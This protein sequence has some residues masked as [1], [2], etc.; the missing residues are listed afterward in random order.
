MTI[1][2]KI[3]SNNSNSSVSYDDTRDQLIFKLFESTKAKD[4]DKIVK[5]IDLLKSVVNMSDFLDSYSNHEMLN[6]WL[7]EANRALK[8]G[9]LKL[10]LES[11]KRA[12]SRELTQNLTDLIQI[13][14]FLDSKFKNSQAY[15]KQI[16]KLPKID[17][18]IYNKW[19]QKQVELATNMEQK[20][21]SGLLQK[22]FSDYKNN[23]FKSSKYKDL[24][25]AEIIGQP[26]TKASIKPYFDRQVSFHPNYAK[27]KLEDFVKTINDYEFPQVKPINKIIELFGKKDPTLGFEKLELLLIDYPETS[28]TL[29]RELLYTNDDVANFLNQTKIREFDIKAIKRKY[30]L[31]RAELEKKK[32]EEA[33]KKAKLPEDSESRKNREMIL[34][35]AIQRTTK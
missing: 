5:N 23:I 34:K 3:S 22:L 16:G 27:I 8:K 4:H 18:P 11:A 17:N 24:A 9:N 29:Q 14:F 6:Q 10:A 7:I 20:E 25:I 30:L 26:A 2:W 31:Y 21:Y 32:L 19:Y 15:L 28:T 35:K 33:A 12:G 13:Q 1:I